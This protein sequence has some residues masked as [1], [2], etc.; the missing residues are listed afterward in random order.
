VV[1][2][3]QLARTWRAS[4]EVTAGDAQDLQHAQASRQG[5]SHPIGGSV[6]RRFLN[7]PNLFGDVR[8]HLMNETASII[9]KEPDINDY[10]IYPHFS[11]KVR[12]SFP[13]VESSHNIGYHALDLSN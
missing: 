1:L 7:P 5:A 13:T 9:H 4:R 6:V 3:L 10:E 12:T 11:L 8:P 2:Q